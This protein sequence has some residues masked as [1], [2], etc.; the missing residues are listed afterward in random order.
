MKKGLCGEI[1]KGRYN[2]YFMT[3]KSLFRFSG[4]RN[5]VFWQIFCKTLQTFFHLNEKPKGLSLLH[6]HT[7]SLSLSLWLSF[8]FSLSVI[9][10]YTNSFFCMHPLPVHQSLL[11]F[12]LHHTYTHTHPRR[13][14]NTH[15][16]SL[17]SL[18]HPLTF[19][20]LS[21]GHKKRIKVFYDSISLSSIIATMPIFSK[22]GPLC[23]SV[24][25]SG[26]DTCTEK[27][28]NRTTD[29]IIH[30]KSSKTSPI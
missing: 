30:Q 11:Q 8:S 16:L 25:R 18:S 12:C 17:S 14:S 5:A 4:S 20:N 23:V 6:T 29:A 21:S 9:H 27:P 10:T 22:N 3:Q 2:W 19:L 15:I 7:L 13:H 26:R 1:N 24:F 28:N